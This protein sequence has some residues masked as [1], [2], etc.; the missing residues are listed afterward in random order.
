MRALA[1]ASLGTAL[2]LATA[3]IAHAQN[4]GNTSGPVRNA[5]GA[6][7]PSGA[8]TI[9]A[10][11]GAGLVGATVYNRGGEAVGQV[12]AVESDR[13]TVS[14]GSYLGMGAKDIVLVRPNVQLT[15]SGTDQRLIT[16]LTKQE[17]GMQPEATR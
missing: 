2:L 13:L 1:L 15:G 8:A 3:G 4:P 6:E 17:L 9:G 11:F 7:S 14:V 12:R 16:N 10:D 5:P